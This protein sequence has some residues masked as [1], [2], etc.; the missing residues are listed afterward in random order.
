MRVESDRD[1]DLGERVAQSVRE[2][3]LEDL[4]SA[5]DVALNFYGQVG[6]IF[7]HQAFARLLSLQFKCQ[8]DLV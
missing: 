8:N 7:D 5:I 3:V 4:L 6:V 2:E 1:D